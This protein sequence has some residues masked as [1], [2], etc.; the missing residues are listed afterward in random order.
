[1]VKNVLALALLASLSACRRDNVRGL[2]SHPEV[3]DSI[4]FGVLAVNQVRAIPISVS[5]IGQIDLTIDDL[6]IN[7]PFDV[8]T[9]PD[10]VP[11]GGTGEVLVKFQPVQPG[12]VTG[13]VILKTSSLQAP[14]LTVKLHG[15]AYKPA[16][17]VAPDRLDFGDVQVGAQR[18]LTFQ[19][20]NAS[21]VALN[22]DAEMSDEGTDFSASPLGLLGNLG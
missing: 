13:Q 10:P 20:T 18:T 2:D 4:D 17:L 3:P 16:L 8:A 6:Q 5:N 12:D 7:E 9:P 22:V 1:M 11:P 14:L 15:I 21:P 19:V